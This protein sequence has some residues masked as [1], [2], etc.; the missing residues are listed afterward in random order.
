[1]VNVSHPAAA[2]GEP[3]REDSDDALGRPL[4][5]EDDDN[6]LNVCFCV[7][8]LVAVVV[9]C[10]QTDALAWLGRGG[11]G[12]GLERTKAQSVEYYGLGVTER[13]PQNR[14][15]RLLLQLARVGGVKDKKKDKRQEL[16]TLHGC[17]RASRMWL[18]GGN[19][20]GRQLRHVLCALS[21]ILKKMCCVH[22]LFLPQMVRYKYKW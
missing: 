1:M 14:L 3:G 7:L 10:R 5:H 17:S 2:G 19:V 21:I 6:F 20:Q 22:A 16:L 15:W 4:L 18:S 13:P 12:L 8:C 11:G 9:P